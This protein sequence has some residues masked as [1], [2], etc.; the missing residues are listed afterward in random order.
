MEEATALTKIIS[1]YGV[2]MVITAITLYFYVKDKLEQPKKEK[3]QKEREARKEQEMALRDEE[4]RQA[5]KLLADSTNNVAKALDLLRVAEENNAILLRQHDERSVL[6]KDDMIA[7]FGEVRKDL[8]EVK[9]IVSNCR[10]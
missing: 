2:L 9:T 3:E 6:I 4:Y 10:R 8:V 7:G 5:I 1:E